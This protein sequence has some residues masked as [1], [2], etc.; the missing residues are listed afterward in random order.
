MEP[1]LH[2]FVPTASQNEVPAA[3][4]EE[5]TYRRSLRVALDVL[6][7]R[8]RLSPE[9]HPIE[10][11]TT[12]SQKEKPDAVVALQVSSAPSP[13]F[14]AEDGQAVAA[15]CISQRRREC[16]PKSPTPPS[17]SE[18]H[19][20][21]KVGPK[22]DLSENG[23]R[24]AALTGEDDDSGSQLDHEQESTT[25]KRSRNSGEKPTRRRRTESGLSKG[26]SVTES[27]EQASSCVA[28]ASP[29]LPSQ[30]REGAPCAEVQGCEWVESS[31]S[32]G[33]HPAPERSRVRP[34]KR[35]RLDGSQSPPTRQLGTRTVGTAPSP[36]SCSGEV[37]MLR[38]AGDSD[39]PE[40][41]NHGQG[42]L[43][44]GSEVCH[45]HGVCM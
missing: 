20:R 9:S 26:E 16:S 18:D 5:L 35:P 44:W 12:L 27:E 28:L 14:L 1:S 31:G 4:L 11:V 36:Q 42:R 21:C 24:G 37:M 41:G 7:E 33:P 32:T 34:T 3:P 29:R 15:Q 22:T 25:G 19:L 10:D 43:L 39:K 6:N 45:R 8:T 17:A 38:H 13:S 40:E 2:S 30:T 23:A